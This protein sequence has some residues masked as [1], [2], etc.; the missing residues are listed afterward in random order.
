MSVPGGGG[1]EGRCDWDLAVA[2]VRHAAARGLTL[3]AALRAVAAQVGVSE[4]TL[5]RWLARSPVPPSWTQRPRL[6]P[7]SGSGFTGL[8]P[9]SRAR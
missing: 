7:V 4:R 2:G 6:V 5:W 8:R 1:G 9:G 3:R